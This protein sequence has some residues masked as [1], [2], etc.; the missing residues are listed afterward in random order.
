MHSDLL[1]CLSGMAPQICF[2]HLYAAIYVVANQMIRDGYPVDVMTDKLNKIQ[3]EV[4]K[5]LSK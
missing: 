1:K 3:D 5:G 2:D 4:I